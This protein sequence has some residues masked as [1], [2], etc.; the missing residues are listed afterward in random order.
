MPTEPC[1][2]TELIAIRHGQ[3]DA[4]S[5]GRLQG[6]F[7]S[8]LDPEGVRQAEC[9]ARRLQSEQFDALYC[10]DLIRAVTT[11]AI[12]GQACGLRPESLPELREWHMGELENR[13]YEDLRRTHPEIMNGFK[14]DAADLHIPGGETKTAF[15][16]RIGAVMDQLAERHPGGRILVVTHGGVLQAMLKHVLGKG[17]SWNFLPRSANVGYNLFLRRPEGWQLGCWNDT[18]HVN[19]VKDAL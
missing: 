12:V 3:T 2:F 11:A 10:S 7:D 14:F 5:D 4:N 8:P 6:H 15:Y 1:P 19:G 16:R 18:S 9:L 17:N 13:R